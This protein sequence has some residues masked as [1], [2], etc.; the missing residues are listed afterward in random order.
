MNLGLGELGD[1]EEAQDPHGAQ[2][3]GL[4][5]GHQSMISVGL[6]LVSS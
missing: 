4:Q 2:A 6:N 1:E 5:N 3:V